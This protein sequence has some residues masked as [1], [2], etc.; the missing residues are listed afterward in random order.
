MDRDWGYVN[1]C[2]PGDSLQLQGRL[3]METRHEV[4]RCQRESESARK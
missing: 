1:S 2:S 4:N 3:N